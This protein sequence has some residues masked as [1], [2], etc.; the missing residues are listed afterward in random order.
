MDYLEDHTIL[1]QAITDLYTT[2]HRVRC[3][4]DCGLDVTKAHES[5][6]FS[7]PTERGHTAACGSCQASWLGAHTYGAAYQL[8]EAPGSHYRNCTVCGYTR[9]EGHDWTIT[10]TATTHTRSCTA[11]GASTTENHTIREPT[12][13]RV[14]VR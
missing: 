3:Q 9:T 7:L 13:V 5:L 6:S 1:Y 14:Y 12:N 4:Q 2:K 10:K 11:C 8:P